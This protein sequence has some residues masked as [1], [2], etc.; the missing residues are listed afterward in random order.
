MTTYRRP[1]SPLIFSIAAALVLATAGCAVQAQK[2]TQSGS[3]APDVQK[4]EQMAHYRDYLEA[5]KSVQQPL[6]IRG[7]P[8]NVSISQSVR[9]QV[10]RHG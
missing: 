9:R 6:D 3:V 1:H 4:L 2:A 5:H 7:G 10:E 8:L